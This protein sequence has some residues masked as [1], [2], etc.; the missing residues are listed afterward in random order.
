MATAEGVPGKMNPPLILQVEATSVEVSWKPPSK[1]NGIITHYV[2][3]MSDGKKNKTMGLSLT[4][5]GRNSSVPHVVDLNAC[6][7]L[8]VVDQNFIVNIDFVMLKSLNLE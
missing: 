5:R 2:L 6:H 8:N 3:H 4:V 7:T 1:P